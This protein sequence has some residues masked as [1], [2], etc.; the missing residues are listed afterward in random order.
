MSEWIWCKEVYDVFSYWIA[1]QC[2]SGVDIFLV[3]SFH[4]QYFAH[5]LACSTIS[6]GHVQSLYRKQASGTRTIVLRYRKYQQ[7]E[8]VLSCFRIEACSKWNELSYLHVHVHVHWR[9]R[10]VAKYMYVYYI[11]KLCVI[12]LHLFRLPPYYNVMWRAPKV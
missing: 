9:V 10:I 4:V 7:I 11:F 5:F 12:F 8:N 2:H 1:S 6:A 3:N